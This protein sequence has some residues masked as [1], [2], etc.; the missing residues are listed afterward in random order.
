MENLLVKTAV[1][2]LDSK[3]AIDLK[4]LKIQDLTVLTDY[5]IIC[6]GSSST[7]V[8]ALADECE[9]QLEQKGFRCV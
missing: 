8:K 6:H 2:A 4:V 1:K 9:Y 7:Q 5:F 3:K